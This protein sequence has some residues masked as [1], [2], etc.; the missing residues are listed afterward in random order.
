MENS[1]LSPAAQP[2]INPEAHE[3]SPE[4][5]EAAAELHDR[6][7]AWTVPVPWVAKPSAHN[8]EVW[9]I[10]GPKDASLTG[11]PTVPEIALVTCAY[12]GPKACEE[13]AKLIVR[14]VNAQA[15]ALSKTKEEGNPEATWE[16]IHGLSVDKVLL[17]ALKEAQEVMRKWFA[18]DSKVTGEAAMEDLIPILDNKLLVRAMLKMEARIAAR[19]ALAAAHEGGA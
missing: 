11:I 19:A 9:A 2:A 3:I 4:D 8:P 12:Y 15:P 18:P 16:R 7:A 13:A 14:A 10:Y 1:E 17:D 5:L 6:L